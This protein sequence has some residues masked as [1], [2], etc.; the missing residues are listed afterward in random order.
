[1]KIMMEDMWGKFHILQHVSIFALYVGSC[2]LVPSQLGQRLENI[3]SI[4]VEIGGS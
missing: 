4:W 2:P 3:I 1:M